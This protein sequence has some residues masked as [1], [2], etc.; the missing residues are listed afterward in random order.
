MMLLIRG[1]QKGIWCRS[2]VE[3]S[4]N[5]IVGTEVLQHRNAISVTP[6][7]ST[8]MSFSTGVANGEHVAASLICVDSAPLLL[9]IHL[10]WRTSW[11]SHGILKL[12]WG[13]RQMTKPGGY[14]I[15]LISKSS[16]Q[17]N[18]MENASREWLIIGKLILLRVIDIVETILTFVWLAPLLWWTSTT[19]NLIEKKILEKIW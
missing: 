14:A 3:E 10:Y 7:T 17:S 5:T 18:R 16:H 15:P 4:M 1:V 19:T 9:L 8:N 13:F 2:T 6:I 12:L 11:M